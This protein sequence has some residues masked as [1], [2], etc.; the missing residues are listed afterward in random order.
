MHI[1]FMFALHVVCLSFVCACY[2]LVFTRVFSLCFV[3]CCFCRYPAVWKDVSIWLPPDGLHDNDVF[4]HVRAIAG[5]LVESVMMQSSFTHPKSGRVSRLY[6]I[7]YRS[8]D[9]N[10]T[11]VEIDALQAQLRAALAARPGLELR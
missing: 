7:M 10:L 6:R 1:A 5:D 2:H 11:N 4:E 3:T 8:M 9:R